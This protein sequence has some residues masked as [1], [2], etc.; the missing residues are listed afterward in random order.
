M[1]KCYNKTYPGEMLHVVTK[2]LPLLKN[3]TKQQTRE[4]SPINIYLIF[5][6][7][8]HKRS[9]LQKL[10]NKNSTVFVC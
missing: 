9:V 1:A 8:I 6:V 2:G 7:F 5:I 10:F 4:Y 3:E